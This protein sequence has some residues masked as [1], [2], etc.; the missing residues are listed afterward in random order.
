MPRVLAAL[1]TLSSQAFTTE[2]KS[3]LDVSLIGVSPSLTVPILFKDF[4]SPFQFFGNVK[5]LPRSQ[6]LV[7]NVSERRG[8]GG[9]I[10]KG[11]DGVARTGNNFSH[12]AES[13]AKIMAVALHWEN[14][15]P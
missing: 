13:K 14:N 6:C 1:Q 15:P 4:I 10:L 5:W 2:R 12:G 11:R 8:R 7:E 3:V 9:H